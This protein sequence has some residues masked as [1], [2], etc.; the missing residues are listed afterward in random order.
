M[1]QL[2]IVS[3]SR[4]ALA[5]LLYTLDAI[6]VLALS[7][8]FNWTFTSANAAGDVAVSLCACVQTFAHTLSRL[9]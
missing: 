9:L 8:V 7:A 5:K 1:G 3:S 2:Q 6:T 4:L